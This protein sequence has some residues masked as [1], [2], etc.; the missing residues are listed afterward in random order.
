M[1][2]LMVK[3]FLAHKSIHFLARSTSAY[4][5]KGFANGINRSVGQPLG[6]LWSVFLQF[7]HLQDLVIILDCLQY[8][9]KFS[10]LFNFGKIWSLIFLAPSLESFRTPCSW[11]KFELLFWINYWNNFTFSVSF[12]RRVAFV[13]V[14]LTLSSIM[15]K[16]N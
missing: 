5:P 6:L 13:F 9:N 16:R 1:I 3:F 10:C 11:K 2:L 14:Y 7:P 8:V 4:L 12:W 15:Y